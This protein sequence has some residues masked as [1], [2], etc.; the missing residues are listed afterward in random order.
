M[1][2][3]NKPIFDRLQ[4]KTYIDPTTLC[5]IWLGATVEDGYGVISYENKQHRIHRLSFELHKGPI[6]H[7]ELVCHTCDNPP[8]WNP[9]HLFCGTCQ[10]N[11]LDMWHKNRQGKHKRGRKIG[12]SSKLNANEVRQIRIELAKNERTYEDIGR[13]FLVTGTMIRRIRDGLAWSWLE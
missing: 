3:I 6:P 1:I 7:S 4:E 10:D 12:E 2:V 9:E 13:E 11:T 8:C 5:W